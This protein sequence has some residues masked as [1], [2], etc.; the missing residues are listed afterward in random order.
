MR[1]S[2]TSHFSEC[3]LGRWWGGTGRVEAKHSAV[4]CQ[5]IPVVA[6]GGGVS[7]DWAQFEAEHFTY[8]GVL[9]Q[10]FPVRFCLLL[11]RPV[12]NTVYTLLKHARYPM[13]SRISRPFYDFF[14]LEGDGLPEDL[15]KGNQAYRT[16]MRLVDWTNSDTD[17]MLATYYKQVARHAK[18]VV[19]M[20]GDGGMVM[21]Q[22]ALKEQSQNPEVY[23]AHVTVIGAHSLPAMDKNGLDDPFCVLNM[24]PSALCTLGTVKT[25][26]IKKTREPSWNESF[27]FVVTGDMSQCVLR[28][29]V[30]DKDSFSSDPI[31]EAS[32]DFGPITA[33]LTS[34]PAAGG[35]GRSMMLPK[36]RLPLTRYQPAPDVA[37]SARP[38]A[39]C[40]KLLEIRASNDKAAEKEVKAMHNFYDAKHKV[41]AAKD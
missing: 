39:E 4:R 35:A 22:V 31:G 28:I 12:V 1:R 17:Y 6:K 38:L 33:E 30:W 41:Y 8:H 19:E 15:L 27:D 2:L 16:V 34:K 32:L 21:V 11:S 3:A 37:E 7:T 36:A 26:V 20:Q 13:M 29:Q 10:S 24:L 25:K 23:V 9:Y 5:A 40:F 14:W 18:A